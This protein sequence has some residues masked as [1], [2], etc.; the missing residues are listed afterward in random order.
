MTLDEAIKKE[1]EKANS[2]INRAEDLMRE[3]KGTPERR[4]CLQSSQYHAQ[5]GLWLKELKDRRLMDG[6]E[7]GTPMVALVNG[8][9]E[10]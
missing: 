5:I 8:G 7:G 1:E 6:D 2:L 4:R 9:I 3:G 10:L